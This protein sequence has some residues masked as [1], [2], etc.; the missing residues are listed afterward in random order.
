MSAGSKS[1]FLL[2]L[3]LPSEWSN[4]VATGGEGVTAQAH[5]D[6]TRIYYMELGN[7]Q[8][9]ELFQR[10]E[11]S[12]S[13]FFM[14]SVRVPGQKL[15]VMVIGHKVA[16][17]DDLLHRYNVT[18]HIL[19]YNFQAEIDAN[20][21]EVLPTSTPVTQFD[22]QHYFQL[23][24]IYDWL[25]HVARQSPEIVTVL[26]MGSS[27]EGV[28]IKG[29]RI[30]YPQEAS[31]APRTSVFIES[32]IH[33]REWIAPATAT[34]FINELLHSSDPTVQALARSQNWLIFPCINPDGYKYTFN[35]DRMWRKSRAPH[36]VC[37]GVDLNRNYPMRWNTTG[38]S[39]D[40][41]STFYSGPSAG[42]EVETQR[43]MRFVEKLVRTEN[44]RTY[45]AL[46]S[47]SQLLMFP[48][49]STPERV[50]NYD[51]LTAIGKKAVA[52]IKS[53]TGRI[54]KSGSIYE[55]IYPSSGGSKD[56]AHGELKLNITFTF[57]LRGPPDSE[58]LF[59]LPAREIEPTAREAFG[60]VQTIVE[61][62]AKRGYYN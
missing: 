9:V 41:C 56:W 2:L 60:A 61:E 21:R 24:T 45:I 35:G 54:Y 29:V 13:Y 19:N 49:S 31:S 28:P 53:L 14:G 36:G 11:K 30:S 25:E 42:S 17:F 51:D 7:E 20:Y 15:T 46:H 58:V 33:A 1:I 37:R 18:H 40:P 44:L 3:L 16:D 39:G 10:L 4:A 26:D 34:Y 50:H 5:Y 43:V 55:T 59:I 57:E 38:T 32:G 6:H 52:K 12:D 22:W 48:Y 27:T 62:A 8:H 47:Y 23:D